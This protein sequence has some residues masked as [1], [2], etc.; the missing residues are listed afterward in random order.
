MEF[1]SCR[2]WHF[3]A[4]SPARSL[5]RSFKSNGQMGFGRSPRMKRRWRYVATSHSQSLSDQAREGG[6]A[7]FA[8]GRI[9]PTISE[10]LVDQQNGARICRNAVSVA[11]RA[12]RRIGHG[13]T[14]GGRGTIYLGPRKGQ[15]NSLLRLPFFSLSHFGSVCPRTIDAS[16]RIGQ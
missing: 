5:V 12:T 1:S 15:K 8:W 10:L 4:G 7:T 16:L 3:G 6:R 14:G 2:A 11:E 13:Q 9:G